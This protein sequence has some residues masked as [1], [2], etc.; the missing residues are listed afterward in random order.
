MLHINLVQEFENKNSG[1]QEFYSIIFK[2]KTRSRILREEI[3]N[4]GKFR[5]FQFCCG[6]DKIGGKNPRSRI[7]GGTCSSLHGVF[8]DLYFAILACSDSRYKKFCSFDLVLLM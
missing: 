8:S 1:F 7:S 6:R 4:S 2:F 3:L 5:D